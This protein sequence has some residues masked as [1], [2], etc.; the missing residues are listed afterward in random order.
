M[1]S[2]TG[3]S[4]QQAKIVLSDAK[5]IIVDAAAG[6]GKTRTL[7]E[8]VRY[9]LECGVDPRSVVVI[10]FTNMA[11]DE[12]YSRLSDE[13]NHKKLFIGTIHSY[14]NKVLKKTGNN[15]EI[16]SELY[17][18]QFM[19][20]LISEYAKYCTQA[21]YEL[22]VKYSKMVDAGKLSKSE[23]PTL[24]S[25]NKVYKELMY[26]LG[27]EDNYMYP[28]TVKTLCKRNN[29]ITFDELIKLA[30]QY[31]S[32][33]GTHIDYLFVDELQDIGKLEYDF[34]MSLNAT[35]NFFIGDDF[36]SIFGFKGGNVG[37]F[38]SLMTGED[39]TP[40]Y[41]TENYRTASS[42]LTFAN[43]VIK[44]ATNIIPKDVVG[45]RSEQGSLE[46]QSKS[47]VETFIKDNVKQD[48]DWFLLTRTNKEMY[49]IESIL[50]KLE[51]EYYCF[52][53]SNVSR[54][55]LEE[56]MSKKCV[57]VMTVH[58]S[59]GLEADNVLLY[60]KFPVVKTNDNDEYKVFYVGITRARNRLVVTI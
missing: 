49:Y 20:G 14:A 22:F 13:P 4:D 32:D 58:A 18:T 16:F 34:L 5:N 23:L 38:L 19:T 43:T 39:W 7:T 21:D 55:K 33:T 60:G 53:Q 12:L 26:L 30:T 51:M 46:F 3:L 8:R 35:N 47:L 52:K 37:I 44:K 1:M 59:K 11:A 42:I 56:I 45:V 27:E 28:E 25:S 48:Q 57:K 10:T 40:F 6:S 31:F 15:F 24:F 9:I 17:Q 2:R 41:L 36:Q 50:K 54:K 29:I